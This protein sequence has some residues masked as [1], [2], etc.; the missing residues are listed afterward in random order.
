MNQPTFIII[1]MGY[2]SRKHLQAIKDVGGRLVAIYEPKHENLGFTQEYFDYDIPTFQE[3]EILDRHV[4]HEIKEG[5][6]IDYC[7]ICSPN[8]THEPLARWAMRAG[9]NCIVEKPLCLREQNLD[10]IIETEL[11]TGKRVYPILQLRYNPQIKDM[12]NTGREASHAGITYHT[13]RREWYF[14]TWK[15]DIHKSGGLAT[16]IGVHLFDLSY[17]IFGKHKT[18]TVD[19]KTE[20]SIRG[21]VYYESGPVLVYDLAIT[22]CDMKR[23]LK[24]YEGAIQ[25]NLSDGFNNLHTKCYEE[26]LAG[27]GL[28]PEDCRESIKI[29]EKIRSL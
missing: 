29:C 4:Y 11:E 10:S 5:R 20:G 17:C 8:Y 27:R 19:I 2:V 26:I 24:I 22:L 28:T 21:R 23:V 16:N 12:I 9:M 1:G 25:F 6:P 3:L 18:I 14:R 15:N 13:P 7:V